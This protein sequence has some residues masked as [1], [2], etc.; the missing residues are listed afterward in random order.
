MEG[1]SIRKGKNHQF[2][3][4]HG[5]SWL[6]SILGIRGSLVS[7]LGGRSLGFD[8]SGTGLP[9]F[10]GMSE[11]FGGTDVAAGTIGEFI[12]ATV[13]SWTGFPGSIGN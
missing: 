1:S 2:R 5:V 13:C 4:D 6:F 3:T 7:M 8:G 9:G 11:P 12:D 10:T